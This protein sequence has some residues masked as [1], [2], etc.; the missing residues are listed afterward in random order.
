MEII[1]L[2]AKARW[3]RRTVFE[4]IVNAKRGHLG[5]SLSC[6]D[7]M[8]A[9]FYQVMNPEDVFILSKGHAA[10]VLYAIL[11]D[12]GYFPKEEL[13]T[14]NLPGSRLEG[15]PH[16][17]IPG[18][19]CNSGSLGN[20]LG[21]ACGVAMARPDIRVYVLLGDGETEEGS[22]YEASLYAQHNSLNITALVDANGYKATAEA[23]NKFKA[24]PPTYCNGSQNG[25]LM[26][27]IV[28]SLTGY[29][30]EGYTIIPY[31]TIKGRGIS[32]MENKVEW[33]HKIPNEA[34]IE[35]ARRELV[36]EH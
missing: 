8:V 15:H 12:K 36:D 6:V 16:I 4:M 25:H 22:S 19:F 28:D 7:I 33:H 29:P 11:A 3:V 30:K 21:I 23:I 1:E 31:R 27:D 5:G 10:P 26:T 14:F 2:E 32:F 17:G 20:G 13:M 18:V 34:E 35:Q 9:L 24:I